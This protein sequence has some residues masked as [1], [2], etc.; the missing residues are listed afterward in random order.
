MPY[1][2]AHYEPAVNTFVRTFDN[3]TVTGVTHHWCM[4]RRGIPKTGANWFIH[5]WMDMLGVKQT[6]MI[7]KCGWSK[8]SASQIYN[9]KQDYSPKIVREAALA[10]NLREYELLMHP[11]QAMALRRLQASAE[12]IVTIA[13][14]GEG[15]RNGT[16]G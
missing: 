8:A 2:F 16:T 9:G 7:E 13:H 15:E 1:W 6:D 14:A 12:E 10:L 5:E 11:D 4:T 3:D